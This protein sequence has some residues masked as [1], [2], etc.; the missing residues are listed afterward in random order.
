MK[1]NYILIAI[2]FLISY[3][4]MFAQRLVHY[5]AHAG[6]SVSN[7]D[8]QA[9]YQDSKTWGG[10]TFGV[11]ARI[12]YRFFAQPQ[13]DYLTTS[14]DLTKKGA[15]VNQAIVYGSL[16]YSM[17]N[18]PVLAGY[19][20]FQ[21]HDEKSNFRLMAGGAYSHILNVRNSSANLTKD[22]FNKNIFSVSAGLGVDIK[23]LKIDL[24]G[25]LGMNDFYNNPSG[26]RNRMVSLT[27]GFKI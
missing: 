1:K 19:K 3:S 14:T 2:L 11:Y 4:P 24:L 21:S 23:Y 17:L 8:A 15:N 18:I 6:V 27:V 13:I 10:Y 12:G 16:D 22:D 20:I 7:A 26:T 9:A 5:G 25:Q